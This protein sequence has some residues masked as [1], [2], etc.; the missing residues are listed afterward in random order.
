[1][2]GLVLGSFPAREQRDPGLAKAGALP[3]DA[4]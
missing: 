4:R 3:T 2:Q 1:M